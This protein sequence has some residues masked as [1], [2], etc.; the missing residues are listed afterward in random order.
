MQQSDL[1]TLVRVLRDEIA[2]HTSSTSTVIID[3]PHARVSRYGTDEQVKQA[4]ESGAVPVLLVPPLAVPARCYDLAP[5]VTP[6]NSVVEFLLS[7]GTIPYVVDFGDVGRAERHLGFA[8]YFDSFIPRAIGDVLTDFGGAAG[9]VDLMAWSLGG[10]LSLLTAAND[11][12]LPIRSIITV[13]TPL[14]YME[15][16]P[17]PLVKLIL[18]PTGG[19]PATY[20]LRALAGIPAPLVRTVYRGLA[21]DRELRKP[22]YIWKNRGDAEAL[23]RMQVIDRF[24]RSLPGYPGKVAEQML[25]NFIVRDE[26]STGVVRFDTGDVDLTTITAPV[27]MVGSPRDVIAP[28]GAVKHGADLLTGSVDR[29]FHTVSSSHLG[30]LTG[31][32]A[33]Q[34]TWPAIAAFR[35]RLDATRA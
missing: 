18:G 23:S 24:Q 19:R 33:Q 4:R 16:P 3:R 9:S 31:P 25:L 27:F 26:L 1:A 6:G 14:N 13:G 29:E 17:Y 35:A 11:P 12:T 2:P 30:M 5:G 10:T 15:I 20:V 28:I 34:H 7:T 22:M 8:D 32:D 21:W